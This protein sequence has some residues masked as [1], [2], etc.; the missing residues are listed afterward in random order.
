MW[1]SRDAVQHVLDRPMAREPGETWAYNSGTSILLGGIIEQVSG[2]SVL[3]FARQNLFDPIG[4][5]NVLWSKTTGGHYHTDGGLYLTPRDM[6]RFGYLMLQGGTWDE[7]EIV[8]ADWVDRSS[9]A[10]YQTPWGYGYGYQWWILPDGAGYG[11]TGHYEQRIFV[12]PE[13]DAVVVLTANIPDDDPNRAD[14]LLYRFILPA[15]ADLSAGGEGPEYARY[16]FT[17]APPPGFGV[18]EAPI[19]GRDTISE[20]S[21]LVQFNAIGASPEIITILWDAAGK[22]TDL[23]AYLEEFLAS[24]SQQPGLQVRPGAVSSA[25]NGD[26]EME[27]QFFDVVTEGISLEGVL[28]TWICEQSGRIFVVSYAVDSQQAPQDLMATFEQHLDSLACH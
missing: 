4:I 17:F 2:Q 5:R 12:L 13:A 22:G 24:I 3:A 21:G 26:H 6:A 16:G 10:Y 8:A 1:E 27:V 18:Q 9:T 25:W 19:P 23:E 11:A 14:G 20:T 7:Q 28:G 15:F